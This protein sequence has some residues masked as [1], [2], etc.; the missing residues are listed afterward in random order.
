[1][2]LGTVG[3]GAFGRFC[4]D[5]YAPLAEVRS[6]AAFD[7]AKGLV[8]AESRRRGVHPCRALDELLSR[9]DVELV[10]VATPPWTHAPVALACLRAGKHVLCEKPLALTLDDADAVLDEA[11]SR[12]LVLAV[13]FVMRYDPVCEAVKR[14]ADS[15]VLGEP[16]FAQFTNCAKDEDLP[17]GHWFWDRARSGGIFVEHAVHFFDLFEWWFGPGR[18]VSATEL[19]R[20]QS[21]ATDQV[22]C[23]VLHGEAPGVLA[24]HYHGFTQAT[25]MDRQEM[26]IVFETGSVRLREWVPLE[27]EA[28]ALADD[29]AI[30]FLDQLGDL[31]PGARLETVE[32]YEGPARAYSSRGVG[33]EA[34]ARVRLKA[35][36]PFESKTA[37]YGHVLGELMRD[38]AAAVLDRSRVPR[39]SGADARRALAVA[40]EADRLARRR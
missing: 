28:E 26:H 20:P 38:V 19:A 24:S 16:L 14:L 17:P 32:R 5:R 37:L 2:G 29:R 6:V 31:L 33:R 18:V 22:A 12:G 30:A 9:H 39:T 13:N 15:R 35:R 23:E 40:L 34:A 11:A 27:M 10:H 3:L 25:R 4:L 21:G 8:E 1:V 7:E 36:A